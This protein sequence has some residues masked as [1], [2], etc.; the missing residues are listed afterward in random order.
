MT[1]PHC[2]QD[3][4][5]VEHRACQ[6]ATLLGDVTCER[7][8][9][10]CSHCHR[11]HFPADVELRLVKRR[12][13]GQREA[14]SLLGV[15]ESFDE[16]GRG[17]LYRLTGISLSAATVRR[18]TEAVGE[19]VAT[20]RAQGKTIGPETAWT[21]HVDAEGRR[22]AYVS[23]D[24]V[25]VLQQG[26]HAEK[27]EPRMAWI[28]AVFN[29]PS[30]TET[31][32]RRVWDRR[33][34]SGLM[35]LPEIGAQIR[36][37]CQAVG[38]AEAD[39]VV[40][41]TDGGNG[42]ENCLL[43]ALGGISQETCFL[44]DF[45]H[46]SEHLREFAK[47]LF[48]HDEERRRKQCDAWCHLLKHHGGD[49]LLKELQSLDLS[50]SSPAAREVHR[51]LLGYIGDNRHRMDYPAY[52]KHGWQIGSGMIESACKTVVNQRLKE[53][54]MRWRQAGT[55][56]LCQLRALYKSERPLWNSY[57]HTSA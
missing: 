30:A 5:F 8:Y 41:L 47:A 2:Q 23:L 1:C 7:A 50:G 32:D 11:G 4:R 38:V 21:W 25:S 28:G 34:V 19:D 15:L 42:L 27:A 57:W 52:V 49:V 44:L 48:P 3:A 51:Q 22:T 24:A 6:V 33:Y 13:P 40:A 20:R 26:M 39:V 45:Y 31:R 54:G 56:E 29:P 12:S 35:S 46:G 14:I 43:D 10:H 36:R 9:Y 53:S 17:S 55:T 37:E 18:V 16:A